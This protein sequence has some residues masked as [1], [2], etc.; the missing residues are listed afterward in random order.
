MMKAETKAKRRATLAILG[1][2]LLDESELDTIPRK[3]MQEMSFSD[4]KAA[5][6]AGAQDPNAPAAGPFVEEE[7]PERTALVEEILSAAAE[8]G[9]GRAQLDAMINKR[10]GVAGGLGSCGDESLGQ[11]LD[12]LKL[13]R[14]EIELQ[15][16]IGALVTERGLAGI[17]DEHLAASFEGKPVEKLKLDEL[18]A[19]LKFLSD[20][21]PVF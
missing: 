10:F 12:G 11:V 2:G 15:A 20:D 5:V 1:L 7:S 18:R 13:R 14:E 17:L 21:E 19:V 8:C 4:P 6:W 3:S 16:Q 9:V